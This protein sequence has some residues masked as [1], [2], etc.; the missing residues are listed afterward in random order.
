MAAATEPWSRRISLYQNS[1]LQQRERL[2]ILS[3]DRRP[4]GSILEAPRCN[5]NQ[6]RLCTTEACMSDWKPENVFHKKTDGVYNG[7][8]FVQRALEHLGRFEKRVVT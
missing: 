4:Q 3:K 7:V 8:L 1:N 6:S 2:C 5:S